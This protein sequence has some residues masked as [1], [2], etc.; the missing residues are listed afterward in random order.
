MDS[1]RFESL[2]KPY[3]FHQVMRS[4]FIP[5]Q[6][7][8]NARQLEFVT[9]LDPL[10]DRVA[11]RAGYEAMGESQASITEHLRVHPDVEG[12]VLG[13]ETRLRQII[14]NLARCVSFSPALRH[15]TDISSH[16]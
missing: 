12:I 3:P 2:S 5:L 15:Q 7:A 6:L 8:T 4:L 16:Q 14:T 13:D 11:R 1:G 9:D 10:I